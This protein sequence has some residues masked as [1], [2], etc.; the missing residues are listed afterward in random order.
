MQ[1]KHK[2]I[3]F[4]TIVRKEVHRIF[5][6]WPQTL[7]P[8]VI[9]TSL[10]FL[11]FGQ[12]VGK[13]IGTMSGFPYLDFIAPGLII[14]SIITNSYAGSVSSFYGAKFGRSIEELLV[15]PI[16]NLS[17]LSG[18]VCGGVIRGLTCATL[19]GFITL[20][21][22]DLKIHSFPMTFFVAL[23]TALIFATG[24]VFN[25]IFAKSFD[26]VS[27]I[28]TFILTPLTYLG[29]IFYSIHLLQGVWYYLS[30]LNP[31]VYIINAF[32]F[33]F[34]GLIDPQIE[35]GLSFLIVFFLALFAT[36]LQLLKHSSGLRQ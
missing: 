22:T 23:L 31:I 34:L 35:F 16:S 6:I 25:A 3:A 26:D 24:G 29:G 20:L 18:Y 27:I 11:I 30:L 4:S 13:R 14:L 17:I 7:L 33:G 5:R 9:T 19:V 10:Y 21:F 36:T 15:S 2:I 1:T 28:P 32:R 8:T 12:I